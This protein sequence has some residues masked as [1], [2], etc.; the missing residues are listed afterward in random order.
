[1]AECKVYGRVIAVSKEQVVASAQAGREPFRKRE[2]YIDCTRYDPYTG[3]RSEYENKPL[4]EFNGDKTLAKVNPVLDSLQKDDVVAISFDLQG[5]KIT[6]QQGQTKYFT[7]IRCYAIEVVRKAGQQ[8]AAP[9]PAPA[10]QSPAPAQQQVQQPAPAAAP[11]QAVNPFPPAPTTQ[12]LVDQQGNWD[13]DLP[14]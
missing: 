7:A 9:A 6:N 1:M 11:Q 4:L 5:R 14:F 12:Q 2:I 8:A 3:T 13:N 10:V